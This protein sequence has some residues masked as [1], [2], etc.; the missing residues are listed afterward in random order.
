MRISSVEFEG[1]RTGRKITAPVA[2]AVKKSRKRKR[3]DEGVE[4]GGEVRLPEIWDR[5]IRG[6]GSTGVVTFVDEAS[7]ETALKEA[8][9]AAKGGRE[10]VWGMGVEEKVAPLGLSREFYHFSYNFPFWSC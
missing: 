3:A 7:A 5:V 6:S 2:P 9:R 4:E 1:A 8:R 10:V